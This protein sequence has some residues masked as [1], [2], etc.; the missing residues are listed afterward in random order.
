MTQLDKILYIYTVL[1]KIS[2]NFRKGTQKYVEDNSGGL[3]VCIVINA[4]Y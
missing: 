3:E 4:D 2:D 1:L